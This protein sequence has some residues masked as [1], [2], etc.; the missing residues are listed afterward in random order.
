MV[1]VLFA[2][3]VDS[4]GLASRLD[5]ERAREVLGRFYDVATE[6]LRAQ[7]GQPEKFIGDAVMAVFG[8]PQVHETDALRAVRAGLAI[9]DR[10]RRLGD[11]LGL[12]EPLEVRVGI[13]SGEAATGVGP[14]G[15]LLVTGAVVNAAARLQGAA[16]PGEVLAGETTHQL[17]DRQV[18]FGDRRDVE[19][20][21]FTETLVAYPVEGLSVRSARRTIPI[22][23]RETELGI[24]RESFA[25]VRATGRPLL[26]TLLGEPGIGKTRVADEFVAELEPAIPVL[27]GRQFHAVSATFAPV[28]TIVEDLAGIGDDD[29]PEDAVR[30][31]REVA[32]GCCDPTEAERVA[33]RLALALGITE[34][35]REESAFVQE[36]QSGFLTLVEGLAAREP[37][38]LVFDDA[39]VLRPP[40]LDL[41]ER[42]T[43]RTRRGPA[44]ALVFAIARPELLGD[45]PTWGSGAV[46]HTLLRLEP[47]TSDEAVELAR[48]ASGGR[49]AERTAGEIAART[50]GNPFFI[51]EI[52]GMLL[53]RTDPAR[54][55]APA[56]PPTVQAVVSSRL[57]G[58]PPELRE[59]ARRAS[60]F[61]Y[62]FDL[63]ELG[64]VADGGV[65][66]LAALEDEEILVREG[67]AT[68]WWR[69]RHEMLRDVAYASLPKRERLRLH[70]TIA[71]ELLAAGHPSFAA[72]HLEKAAIAS[73]DLD[74]NDRTMA[75]R[76]A[77]GLAHAG[78]RARRRLE[79]RSAID[80]YQRA[81]E[82]GGPEE[83]WGVREARVLAGIGEAQ[84]WLGDYPAAIEALDRAVEL[85]SKL[86]DPSTLALAL[87]FLGDIATNFEGD[88]DK[89]GALLARSLEA[90][91]E[92]GD[93]LAISRTLL[94]AGWVPWTR[95]DFAS[96]DAMWNRALELS[97]E[98]EDGWGRVRALTALSISSSDQGDHERAIT[99]IEEARSLAAEMDDQFSLAVTSV[100]RGRLHQAAGEGEKAIPLFEGAIQIFGT[101]GARWE[102][103]DATAE[104]GITFREMGRLDEAERDLRQAI[105]ISQQLGE[106]QLASWTWRAL[107]KV[108]QKRGDETEAEERFRR[109][110]EE[111]ARRP[112]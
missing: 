82:M 39:H 41:V 107:A 35:R 25:R 78:D 106:R 57:D 31:L 65:E 68:P 40:M 71:E 111:E 94:F 54:G 16:D 74:P 34:G 64:T 29:P 73:L 92:L 101:L 32:D 9:R 77:D 12:S 36:V 17:T 28:A 26:V 55:P 8:L 86:E 5:A 70:T 47:L 15:Q 1:T 23:G 60:V 88:L 7:R 56:I 21:G 19:A 104:R 109:A 84:Y 79:S 2:D 24:L 6:E 45:R 44:S 83:L 20:K 110:A 43:E 53:G 108:S 80:I 72:G 89:A 18:A 10:T 87:R 67:G 4:T 81:L 51:V 103:A 112:Q 33:A 63:D 75:E 52:T 105:D 30:R 59:L 49:I 42:L 62:S 22:V 90:A 91:E 13:G 3:L 14:A 69:F 66:E 48:E 97:R 58:L 61:L 102:L 85:G 98:N 27:A 100:Q 96:A 11:S 99:L 76:A 38:V 37:I 50:G 95:D 93:P 46:N